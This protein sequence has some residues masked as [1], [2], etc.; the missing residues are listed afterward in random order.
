[1]PLCESGRSRRADSPRR[2]HPVLAGPFAVAAAVAFA[3]LALVRRAGFAALW[4]LLVV[5]WMLRDIGG[6]PEVA[7]LAFIA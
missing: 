2:R 7:P 3:L 5:E 6:R 4:V 1:M